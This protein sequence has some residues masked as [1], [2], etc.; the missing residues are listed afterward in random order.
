MFSQRFFGGLLASALALSLGS[1]L[2]AAQQNAAAGAIGEAAAHLATRGDAFAAASAALEVLPVK[3]AGSCP[4]AFMLK[5]EL[6]AEAPG[7]LAYQ[8]ETLDGRVSQ[9]FETRAK[10][11]REGSFAARIEHQIALQK[12][13]DDGGAGRLAFS[14]PAL[15]AGQP[16]AEPDFFERLFGT[17]AERDPA[18]G[19]GQQSFR[20]KVV[21]PNEMVSA[22]DRPS[23]SC[24]YTELVRVVEKDDDD[25]DPPGRDTPG[26]DPGGRD[27][28]GPAG[29]AGG[30]ID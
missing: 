3:M 20:V 24:E 18:K 17:A 8:I 4:R 27:P 25:R 11:D 12:D 22:F 10:A 29:A 30:A 28:G 6:G 15:P 23:V 13:A 26:R 19:L 2:A 9:V 5:V 7:P 14:A 21:A 1:G 16:A